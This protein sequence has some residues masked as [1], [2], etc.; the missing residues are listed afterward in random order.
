MSAK[1]IEPLYWNV[2]EASL[3]TG[4]TKSQLYSLPLDGVMIVR[5]GRRRLFNIEKLLEWTSRKDEH[6]RQ[7]FLK[8]ILLENRRPRRKPRAATA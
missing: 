5:R 2:T 3:S 7:E 6:S 8:T 4:W 1:E